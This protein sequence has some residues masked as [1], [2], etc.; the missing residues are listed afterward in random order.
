MT[1]ADKTEQGASWSTA[2][3]AVD[4][5]LAP[6]ALVP[7]YQP[8][9]D[10]HDRSVVGFEAL[11]RW[12]ELQCT[13][14]V[15]FAAARRAGRVGELDW[16]CR[17][18]AVEGALAAGL[19]RNGTLFVNVEPA[20][21]GGIPEHVHPW[22][23]L[24]QR[25]LRPMVEITERALVSR[26]A[27]LLMSVARIR[28]RGWGVALDDVGAEPASL[29]MLPLVR[30]DVVKLDLGLVQRRPGPEQ[31]QVVAAVMAYAEHAGAT[32]LAEGI[33]TDADLERAVSFGATLGQGWYF[34]RPGP[35]YVPSSGSRLVSV[36]SRLPVVA[37]PFDVV[38]PRQAHVGRKQ[39]L[40][41]LSRH[42]EDQGHV[43]AIAP[44]MVAAFQDGGRFD[45]ATARRYGDLAAR[46]P[47]VVALG[48]GMASEPAPG[49]RGVALDEDDP[50]RGEWTVAV[51]GVHFAAAL[52][53]RDLGDTGP[54]ADRRFEYVVTHDRARVLTVTRSL[55][56]RAVSIDLP[57]GLC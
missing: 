13:P 48:A 45:E 55:L 43:L 27:A 36:A 11:A 53:G 4:K 52:I 9:V 56:R 34:G 31:M 57:P 42:I 35:L 49:V 32:I 20:V 10:L 5:L 2:G 21:L 7:A 46:C 51:V 8:I 18:A 50:L 23:D 28:D 44:V 25:A 33:E 16:A 22:L 3:D 40:M 12:P 26:P 19:G 39:C 54:D 6:G 14:D 17:I 24:A 41:A 38:E 29:A 47:L 30:P 15:A 37:T 1:I